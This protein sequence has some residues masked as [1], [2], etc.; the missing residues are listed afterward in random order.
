MKFLRLV[1][2][3]VVIFLAGCSSDPEIDAYVDFL[4][5]DDGQYKAVPAS[6]LRCFAGEMKDRLTEE[7]WNYTLVETGIRTSEEKEPDA[8]A[9]D[10]G[11]IGA[12]FEMMGPIMVAAELCGVPM[13]N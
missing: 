7:Q 11:Q 13:E 12:I 1:I 4:L 8:D 2:L 3:P 9:D 6:D 10:W 5:N